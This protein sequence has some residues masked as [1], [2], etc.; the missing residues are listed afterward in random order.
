MVKSIKTQFTLLFALLALAPIAIIFAVYSPS[1]M[2]D[3]TSKAVEDLQ[4]V[5]KGQVHL[6][7]LWITQEARETALIA[8]SP[9]VLSLLNPTIAKEQA[10]GAE[11]YGYSP[12]ALPPGLSEFLASAMKEHACKGI[13]ILDK[14]GTLKASTGDKDLSPPGEALERASKGLPALWASYAKEG[15]ALFISSPVR[16]KADPVGTVV[17]KIDLSQITDVVKDINRARMGKNF[18][19]D[20]TGAIV[21]CLCPEPA[22]D[23]IKNIGK[24]LLDPLTGSLTVGV[25]GCITGKEG[26][27]PYVYT[28]HLG[29]TVLGSW[30]WLKEL[31][32]GIVVEPE[33]ERIFELSSVVRGRLWSL[34][35]V[36]GVGVV[37][38]AV[39]IGRRLSEPLQAL[40]TTAQK[41]AQG[42]LKERAEIKSKDEIGELARCI[43]T[44]VDSLQKKN[45]ELQEANV[46]LAETSIRDGLTGLYNHYFFQEIIGSE[47]HRAKRYNL[48]LTL[49]MIDLDNFKVVNDTCGHPFGDFVLKETARL[50]ESSTRDTDISCRYGGEEFTVLLPNTEVAGAYAVAEKLRQSF[51]SHTFHRDDLSTKLTMTVGISTLAEGG[52]N[53]KDDLTRHADSAL[54][55]GKTRGRNMVVSW[56]E[57]VT[58][59]KITGREEYELSERYRLR[60]QS[61]ARGIKRAYME[62][63]MA[64]VKALE[65]KDGYTATHSYLVA[66]YAVRFAEELKISQENI[67]VIKYAAILH[68]VG[69]IA[70]PDYILKKEEG[71]TEEEYALVK[72]HPEQSAQIVDGVG[73]LKNELPIILHHQEWFNGQG[74]P[75]GLKGTDIPL[76]ARILAICD[77][78]EAM[79][80]HRPYRKTMAS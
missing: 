41:I 20:R 52:I 9:P 43:N 10:V 61:A 35:L 46:K 8:L 37:I 54:L 70:V 26:N 15:G 69:K 5:G 44:V 12:G 33:A 77:A 16:I 22:P 11:P 79:T 59:E 2:K 62:T 78:Y 47:Y 57:L 66:T 60:F 18:L 3:L 45:V 38:T 56:Q 31:D 30:G 39:F 24:K 23:M 64:L 27:S 80:T 1:V 48:P 7:S 14:A 68:D 32:L 21:A 58:W 50:I 25:E 29:K 53:S 63:S 4:S 74:Y 76:G 36:I 71:L 49:L 73:F 34:L 6:I 75:Q 72:R 17:A 13:Y 55:E 42:N 28:N 40:T 51:A 65:A 67:E 19:V